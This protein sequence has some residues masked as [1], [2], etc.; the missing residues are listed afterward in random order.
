MNPLDWS[1]G[2]QL[3]ALVW[4]AIVVASVD[5]LIVWALNGADNQQPL[6]DRDAASGVSR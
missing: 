2:Q 6:A 5:G 1:L 4:V 3:L